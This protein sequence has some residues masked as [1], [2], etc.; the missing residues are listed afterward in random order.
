VGAG[1]AA[2]L[3][4]TCSESTRETKGGRQ[5]S[6][7]PVDIWTVF[8][9]M[10][11]VI[12]QLTECTSSVYSTKNAGCGKGLMSILNCGMGNGFVLSHNGI[13][14]MNDMLESVNEYCKRL[15]NSRQNRRPR[16][17]RFFKQ[18]KEI[19]NMGNGKRKRHEPS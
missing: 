5:S 1:G 19:G 10:A 8:I 7:T 3:S 4:E 11:F 18:C 14:R 12:G 6:D 17:R 9:G 16:T 13:V 2:V 15:V